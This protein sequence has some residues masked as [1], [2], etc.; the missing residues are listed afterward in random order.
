MLFLCPVVVGLGLWVTR[1]GTYFLGV[2]IFGGFSS[3]IVA[4]A[5]S[6]RHDLKSGE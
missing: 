6:C 2:P 4:R 1:G 3:L 5:F